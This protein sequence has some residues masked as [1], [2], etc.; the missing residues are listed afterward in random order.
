MQ[1]AIA[2]V[3]RFDLTLTPLGPWLIRGESLLEGRSDVLKPLL[4]PPSRQNPRP[5]LPGTSLKGVF[6]SIAERILRTVDTRAEP[7]APLADEPFIHDEAALGRL[8]RHQIADSELLAWTAHQQPDVQERLA[9]QLKPDKIYE[10]LSAASQLFGATP[11]AGLV[12]IEDAYASASG[13]P[14]R[15]HVAI[16]RVTGGVGEGPFVEELVPPDAP[17]TT[18]LT[19][20]NFA[21]W[22]IGLMA[23]VFQEINRGYAA[24]GGGTR[25]GQGQFRVDVPRVTFSYAVVAYDV[26]HGIISAQA[27]LDRPPYQAVDVPKPVLRVEMVSNKDDS[28]IGTRPLVLLENL[29]IDPQPERDWRDAGLV[30]LTIQEGAQVTQLLREAVELAWVPWVREVIG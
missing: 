22:Q 1:R 12:V 23:L 15:S 5:I 26:P 8:R 30:M 25:K 7:D 29:H 11:H 10:A 2:G 28:E 24:L 21:L 18:S 3:C 14:R 13:R 27:R 17:L 9:A 20:T 4:E 16:D 6:R 19:I